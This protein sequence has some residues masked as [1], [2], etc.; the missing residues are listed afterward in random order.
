MKTPRHENS[1][2]AESQA[3]TPTMLRTEPNY[4]ASFTDFLLPSEQQKQRW[5]IFENLFAKDRPVALTRVL[6]AVCDSYQ[7]I[8][9]HEH[10]LKAACRQPGAKASMALFLLTSDLV[11]AGLFYEP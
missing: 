9:T 6:S 4:P 5:R 8:P 11:A 1:T 3:L 10:C 2:P 7:A